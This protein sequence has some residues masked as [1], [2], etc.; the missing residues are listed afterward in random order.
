M[1]GPMAGTDVYIEASGAA[2]VI[3]DVLDTPSSLPVSRW[4]PC[5]T[6]DIPVSFLMMLMKQLT[7]C[8]AMEYPER[9]G[10]ASS[11][12]A[13]RPLVADH[14]PLSVSTSSPTRS[15]SLG[16]SRDCGKVMITIAGDRQTE[17]T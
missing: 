10:P 8:G 1:F 11:C 16:G 5:T 6:A 7:I 9:L 15:R 3:G 14:P 2:S 4:W 13:T 17:Q 12:C